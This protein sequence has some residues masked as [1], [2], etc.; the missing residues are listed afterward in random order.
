MN[1][2]VRSGDTLYQI[3]QRFGTTVETLRKIN[4]IAD[5]DVISIG[6]RLLIPEEPGQPSEPI[7]PAPPDIDDDVDVIYRTKNFDYSVD[8]GLLTVFL[9]D[10]DSY[11]QGENI[12][13]TLVKTN[14]TKNPIRLTYRLGQ[15]VEFIVFYEG[16]RSWNWSRRRSFRKASRVITLNPGESLVYKEI[17]NQTDNNGNQVPTGVYRIQG[18]NVAEEVADNRLDI[19]I[20]I[21]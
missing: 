8:N 9:T 20:R 21:E 16:R 4:R 12:R 1:Y 11:R 18:W 3:A 17:W 19:F 6:Q 14:I 10:K 7:E 2:V 13:L 15:R 5:T